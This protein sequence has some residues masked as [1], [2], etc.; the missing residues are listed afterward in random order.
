MRPSLFRHFRMPSRAISVAG[1]LLLVGCAATGTQTTPSGPSALEKL[2]AGVTAPTSSAPDLQ[3]GARP[4]SSAPAD[5]VAAKSPG[6]EKGD[7]SSAAHCKSVLK[8]MID[9]PKRTWV[10]RRQP[11]AAYVNGTRQFAYRALRK[12]LNCKELTLALNELHAVANSF[13]ETVPGVTPNQISRTR[14]LN[15]Q[16]EGELRS[17][18]TTR[19]KA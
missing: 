14:A 2:L 8:A 10:G 19:C 18:R 16:V 13:N 17:E 15:T 6:H 1:G 7:C 9:D 5:A 12:K 11:P 3:T 4:E